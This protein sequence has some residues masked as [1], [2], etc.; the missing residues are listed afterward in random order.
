MK[1]RISGRKGHSLLKLNLKK[2][3][4]HWQPSLHSPYRLPVEF[5][6]EFG[7]TV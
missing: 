3:T 6:L 5:E 4:F 7:K 1:S 2:L